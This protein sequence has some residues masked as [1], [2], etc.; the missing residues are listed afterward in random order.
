[1]SNRAKTDGGVKKKKTRLI[2]QG[3]KKVRHVSV[4]LGNGKMVM[5]R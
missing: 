3:G 1:M 2:F 4:V 5:D